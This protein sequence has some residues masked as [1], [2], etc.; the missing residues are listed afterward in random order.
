MENRFIAAR[1]INL[2]A[3]WT[4]E[5]VNQF[6]VYLRPVL[7]SQWPVTVSADTNSCSKMTPQGTT[8]ETTKNKEN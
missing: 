4:G 8:K 2:S 1:I 5:V 3:T 7:S 6:F